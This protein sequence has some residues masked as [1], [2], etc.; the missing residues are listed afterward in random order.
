MTTA[1]AA[2]AEVA[3][4]GVYLSAYLA[5]FQRLFATVALDPADWGLVAALAAGLFLWI[6]AEKAVVRWFA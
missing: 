1:V 4:L 2:P 3:H 5:P 6:E